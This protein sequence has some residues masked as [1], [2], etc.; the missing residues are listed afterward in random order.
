M[1]MQQ[2][3]A[4]LQRRRG[5][6]DPG[7]VFRDQRGPVAAIDAAVHQVHDPIR[8]DFQ[9]RHFLPEPLAARAIS[10]PEL[11]FAELLCQQQ[12]QCLLFAR[13]E[14]SARHPGVPGL[15]GAAAGWSRHHHRCKQVTKATNGKTT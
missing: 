4:A 14:S 15:M 5:A 3:P 10:Q 6:A 1:E 9:C 7:I 11:G 13:T 12:H 8:I 2:S